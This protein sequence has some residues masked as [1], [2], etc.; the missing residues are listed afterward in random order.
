MKTFNFN[1]N[2]NLLTGMEIKKAVTHLFN[3]ELSIRDDQKLAIIF[4]ILTTDNQWRNISSMQI[5]SKTDLNTL[6]NIF[7]TFWEIRSNVYHSLQVKEIVFRYKTLEADLSPV[8]SIFNKPTLENK[9]SIN[10]L[11]YDNLPSNTDISNWSNNIEMDGNIIKA[12]KD[13]Y[14]YKVNLFNDKIWLILL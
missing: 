3:Y 12:E 11:G 9:P 5:I 7:T 10:L 2:N 4:K 13:F 1:I 14:T 8:E 6:V